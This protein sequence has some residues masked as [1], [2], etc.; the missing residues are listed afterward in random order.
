MIF[1]GHTASSPLLVPRAVA[2]VLTIA[3]GALAASE[4]AAAQLGPP[5]PRPSSSAGDSGERA[6][7][8]AAPSYA[9]PSG[10]G[11]IGPDLVPP[12]LDA[13]RDPNLL[14]DARRALPV[15]GGNRLVP[16]DARNPGRQ[17]IGVEIVGNRKIERKQVLAKIKVRE[18]HTFD[19]EQIER[20]VRE[21]NR[22]GM[23]VE[24]RPK[25]R[26]VGD[27]V[28]VTFEV[29]ERPTIEYV[30]LVGNTQIR[31]KKLLEKIGL[32]VGGP[33]SPYE[34]EEGRRKIE[35][36]Y[37]DR[38]YN[39]MTVS[40]V[41]GTK[42][43]DRGVVYLLNEGQSQKIAWTKFVGNT[44]VSD[45]RLKTQIQSKPGVMW[46][47]GGYVDHKKIEE[48]E[49]RLTAYYRS[50]GYFRAQVR[51]VLQYDE[52][53]EW[54]TLTFVIFEGERYKIRSVTIDG[55]EKLATARLSKDL[56]LAE[57]QFFDQGKM[58][59]D[60]AAMLNEYGGEGYVFA[61]VKPDP[62]FLEEPGQLDLV[63][64]V[65]EGDRYRIGEINVM[66]EGESPHTR[67]NVV[68]NNIHL[69]PGD[70]ADIREIREAQRR[71]MRAGVFERQDPS[72]MPQLKFSRPE[73][74]ETSVVGRG[75][76]RKVRG[77]SPDDDAR[78]LD[79]VLV[80]ETPDS[81][82]TMHAIVRGLPREPLDAPSPQWRGPRAA[83]RA[84]H[85]DRPTPAA[86]ARRYP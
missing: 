40:I 53:R 80:Y 42:P 86:A 2:V 51:R 78:T 62:R 20:D 79:L 35:E 73:D 5:S 85:Y 43:T 84:S 36:F 77:Q 8:F 41:E 47:F 58:N 44:I 46:L 19:E 52:D 64:N 69:R 82:P 71:L 27:G 28:V 65:A 11:A 63:Y 83:P 59:K 81:P 9:P 33:L 4:R 39:R 26:F 37:R 21:L 1:R 16:A 25:S 3:V 56:Q 60:V 13:A 10:V 49:E 30:K 55:N 23:F 68:K 6:A 22:S 31:D 48:D 24:V 29:M 17:V 67:L 66:I 75:G 76:V 38:G 45:A 72:K 7:G 54:L 57:G 12:N 50:L 70:I 32:K 61:D 34:I 14:K 18:G 15:D 74:G